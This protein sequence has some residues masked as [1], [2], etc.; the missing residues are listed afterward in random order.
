[1]PES[2]DVFNHDYHFPNEH[3]R[4]GTVSH[5]A[6]G[7]NKQTKGKVGRGYGGPK[8]LKPHSKPYHA[9]SRNAK[10]GVKD[11]GNEY[12]SPRDHKDIPQKPIA[13]SANGKST[14]NTQRKAKD[15][16]WA[17]YKPGPQ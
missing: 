6:R 16:T 9:D 2:M 4:E 12:R 15:P 13:T 3:T 11:T 8:N 14:A 10:A 1:M 5:K 7:I 17:G